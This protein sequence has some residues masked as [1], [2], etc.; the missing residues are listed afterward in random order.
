[1]SNTIFK[2]IG[3]EVPS[4]KADL[5]MVHTI[6][7]NDPNLKESDL[8][9]LLSHVEDIC[10]GFLDESNKECQNCQVKGSCALARQVHLMTIKD[11]LKSSDQARIK[12]HNQR[13]QLS[14]SRKKRDS[15]RKNLDAEWG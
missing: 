6:E 2:S 7:G 12:T 8:S 11:Q 4:I 10:L 14:K 13:E 15:T 9:I 1:M 5:T 3:D